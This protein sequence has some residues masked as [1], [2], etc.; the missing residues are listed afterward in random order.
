MRFGKNYPIL[1]VA[2]RFTNNIEIVAERKGE[3]FVSEDFKS[4]TEELL[5]WK[6]NIELY[7]YIDNF[8]K[9]CL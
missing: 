8:K 4:D 7:N 2:K 9:H 6:A 5:N 1:D 3:R